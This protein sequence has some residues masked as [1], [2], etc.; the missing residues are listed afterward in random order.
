MLALALM[1][2]L[3]RIVAFRYGQVLIFLLLAVVVTVANIVMM[4]RGCL[5]R[6][7]SPT[8]REFGRSCVTKAKGLIVKWCPAPVTIWGLM[9]MLLLRMVVT[10]R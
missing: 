7:F 6:A 3:L 4:H 5:S 1:Q 2:R 10:R 9:M 8:H